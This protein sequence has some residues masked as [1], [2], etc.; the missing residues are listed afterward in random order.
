M[1][2][3]RTL[4]IQTLGPNQPVGP[5]R[6]QSGRLCKKTFLC[7][8][9]KAWHHV[10]QDHTSDTLLLWQCVNRWWWQYMAIPWWL[11]LSPNFRPPKIHV[12]TFVDLMFGGSL[13]IFAGRLTRTSTFSGYSFS[14]LV[15]NTISVVESRC[16]GLQPIRLA[17]STH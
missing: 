15:K 8:P 16:C 13:P 10:H 1:K 3:T 12:L 14:V 9:L 4:I 7:Y 2:K 5:C 11:F 6:A 17:G